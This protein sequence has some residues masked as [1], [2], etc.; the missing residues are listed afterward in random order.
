MGSP[1]PRWPELRELTRHRTLAFLRQ[2]E[3]VFWVFAFPMI[4][5]AVLGF[6]FQGG[7]PAP[8][9]VGVLEG[10]PTWK[11]SL[12]EAELIEVRAYQTREEA[13]RAL[14]GLLFHRRA[15]HQPP[16]SFSLPLAC[17]VPVWSLARKHSKQLSTAR[18]RAGA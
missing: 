6:A 7:E 9:V 11:T 13:D 10:D 18:T 1:L 8:S 15:R 12:E 2:P 14:R 16:P 3:A 5:A 17:G 4:L